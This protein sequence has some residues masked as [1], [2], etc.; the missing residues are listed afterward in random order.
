FAE[1][2][3]HAPEAVALVDGERHVTYG[4]LGRRAGRLA[5]RLGAAGVEPETPVGLFLERSAEAMI[6][7]LAVLAAGGAYVPI[8]PG[9]PRERLGFLL[10]DAGI[11]AVVTEERLLPALP[12]T[13][14]AVL[15][16]DR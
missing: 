13:G 10:R 4:Q 16:L 14:A 3:G 15:C 8:D 9:Y 5:R 12:Q 1:V 2:A 6:A 7:T 11:A